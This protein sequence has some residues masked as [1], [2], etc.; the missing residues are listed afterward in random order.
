[1]LPVGMSYMLTFVSIGQTDFCHLMR[2][3]FICCD[4]KLHI[5]ILKNYLHLRQL[6]LVGVMVKGRRNKADISG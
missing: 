3:V 2:F 6:V 4:E 1:M 5:H